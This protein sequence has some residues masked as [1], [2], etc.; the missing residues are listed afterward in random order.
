MNFQ[1]T[2]TRAR[3]KQFIA[4]MQSMSALLV[5]SRAG[6]IFLKTLTAA[7]ALFSGVIVRGRSF[8]GIT[9]VFSANLS[10]TIWR[11]FVGTLES[12]IGTL[13][14]W[15]RFPWMLNT[16]ATLTQPTLYQAS[17]IQPSDYNATEV[18]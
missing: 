4:A 16:N 3:I 2:L 7:T 10:K 18:E 11:S 14:S 17:M 6:Y 5:I 1:G 9:A 15:R 13:W 12:F 8:T